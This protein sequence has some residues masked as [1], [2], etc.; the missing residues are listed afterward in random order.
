MPHT[1]SGP[2]SPGG[3]PNHSVCRNTHIRAMYMTS[4]D[5]KRVKRK[6]G[7]K[8]LALLGR[9]MDRRWLWKGFPWA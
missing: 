7:I 3:F 1:Y 5:S 2:K 6:D 8:G 4:M 9:H